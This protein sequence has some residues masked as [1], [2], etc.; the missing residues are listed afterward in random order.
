RYTPDGKN[1]AV[2]PKPLDQYETKIDNGWIYLGAI[3]P[4]TVVK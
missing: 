2:A 4:N 3:V 1:L